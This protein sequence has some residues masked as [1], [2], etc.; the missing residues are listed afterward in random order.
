[1]LVL[2]I[3]V[4]PSFRVTLPPL[5]LRRK[6]SYL[7]SRPSRQFPFSLTTKRT[8]RLFV[9]CTP[10]LIL[11]PLTRPALP[12]KPESRSSPYIDFIATSTP[13]R[14]VLTT[15]PLPS[16]TLNQ[17]DLPNRRLLLLFCEDFEAPIIFFAVLS[18]FFLLKTASLSPKLVFSTD[19]ASSQRY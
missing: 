17:S 1:L 16:Q 14:C 8:S 4:F 6:K 15:A 3:Y 19:R 5:L 7:Q 11:F 12:V 2:S 18:F 9:L 10:P 13:F